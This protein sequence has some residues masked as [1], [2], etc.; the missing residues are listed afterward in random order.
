MIIA[1]YLIHQITKFRV[2]SE[3]TF[4][5]RL[6]EAHAM[7]A[8]WKTLTPLLWISALN[9]WLT[10]KVSTSFCSFYRV[11]FGFCV[12]CYDVVPSYQIIRFFRVGSYAGFSF[13]SVKLFLLTSVAFLEGFYGA[14][15]HLIQSGSWTNRTKTPFFTF[16]VKL[17]ATVY[18][19]CTWIYWARAAS[20]LR[21]L[22]VTRLFN[23]YLYISKFERW[24]ILYLSFSIEWL[25]VLEIFCR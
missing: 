1:S 4:F 19:H 17:P 3:S 14:S 8:A 13:A 10:A 7:S 23:I 15:L 24:E 11:I 22:D 16:K 18:N 20:Y 21:N 2:K 12:N 6:W 5:F 25:L 9:S